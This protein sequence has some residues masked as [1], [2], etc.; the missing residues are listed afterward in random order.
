[1]MTLFMDAVSFAHGGCEV[2]LQKGLNRS[3]ASRTVP[4]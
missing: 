1:L 2:R 3:P 4:E